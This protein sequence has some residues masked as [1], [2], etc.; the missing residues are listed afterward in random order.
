MGTGRRLRELNPSIRLISFQP[1][2]PFHGLEGMKYMATSMVP[3]I[4]DETLADESREVSTDDAHEMAIRLAREEGILVGVSAAAA[5][6]C[7]LK[8]AE[9]LEEGVIVTIFCDSGSRYLSEL[10][11]KSGDK[12]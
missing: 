6:V 12:E 8:L 11:W 1:D 9:K 4:Y 5:L 7:S 10:F 2:A 3:A